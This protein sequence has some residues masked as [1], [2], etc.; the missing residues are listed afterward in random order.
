MVFRLF[1]YEQNVGSLG[2]YSLG[3]CR[4]G[5]QTRLYLKNTRPCQKTARLYV[6]RPVPFQSQN[7]AESCFFK[8]NKRVPQKTDYE[9]L[10]R[11]TITSGLHGFVVIY[12]SG[13]VFRLFGYGQNG[14]SLGKSSLGGCRD[15][16]QTRLYL[17]N[18]RPYRQ[19]TPLYVK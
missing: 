17:K 4:D 3:G 14:D 16:S 12:V 15:G 7:I 18:T 1:G 11:E 9:R 19:T 6:E 10:I 2:E 13:M 5:S 8:L